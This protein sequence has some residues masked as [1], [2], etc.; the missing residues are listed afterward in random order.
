MTGATGGGFSAASVA[1]LCTIAVA[2][3]GGAT[4]LLR[5]TL[6]RALRT[7]VSRLDNHDHRLDRQDT[8]LWQVA[9]STARVEG[10]LASGNGR[11][12]VLPSTSLSTELAERLA[13]PEPEVIPP[14]IP[15]PV[16][17]PPNERQEP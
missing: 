6:G 7:I 16:P 8:A 11:G 12:S 2:V 14:E 4:F 15:D 5:A 1:A 9:T 17:D 10:Y 13:P 3:A